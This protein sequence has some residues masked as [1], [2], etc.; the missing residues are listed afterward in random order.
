[1]RGTCEIHN[2]ESCYFTLLCREWADPETGEVY[3][4]CV[5]RPVFEPCFT[6]ASREAERA[7][8]G[9]IPEG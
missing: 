1:M 6:V 5:D 2:C 4:L 7:S 3:W 9:R 8:H